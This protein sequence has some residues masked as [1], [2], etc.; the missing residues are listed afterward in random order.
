MIMDNKS[1]LCKVIFS[2]VS[3][4]HGGDLLL[5]KVMATKWSTKKVIDVY[6]KTNGRCWYCGKVFDGD[7][8]IDHV[9][10]ACRGGSNDLSNLV[11]C[12]KSCNSQKNKKNLEEYRLYKMEQL[13]MVFS[14]EQIRWLHSK[15]III[16]EPDEYL[17]Y[18]ESIGSKQ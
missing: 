8:N 13:G 12:C 11:P 5:E 17:F 6:S 2:Q 9:T 1:P 7:H 15:G 4:L 10:P 3:N 16:P 14:L 18:H